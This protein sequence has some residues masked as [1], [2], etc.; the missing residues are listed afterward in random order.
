MG[1]A[2]LGLKLAQNLTSVDQDPMFLFFLDLKK[3][4]NTVDFGRLLTTLDGYSVAPTCAG[5]WQCFRNSKILSP[6]KTGIIAAL[7]INHDDHSGQTHIV[8]PV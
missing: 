6:A 2:I 5:Y 8:H 1:T 3:A 4:Y 7:H